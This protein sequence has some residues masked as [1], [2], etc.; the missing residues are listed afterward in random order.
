MFIIVMELVMEKNPDRIITEGLS[1]HEGLESAPPPEIVTPLFYHLKA[2]LREGNLL[3]NSSKSGNI[4]TLS[5]SLRVL[6]MLTIGI[7][8]TVIKEWALCPTGYLSL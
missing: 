7:P 4:C 8:V 6:T 3:L 1:D 2:M 5:E